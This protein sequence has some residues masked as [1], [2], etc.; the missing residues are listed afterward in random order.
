MSE[1]KP[2]AGDGNEGGALPNI[3]ELLEREDE[4]FVSLHELL[5]AMAQG[6]RGH[7]S[8]RRT[9]LAAATQEHRPG[10]P[11]FVVQIGSGSRH[12]R[13]WWRTRERTM[14]LSEAGR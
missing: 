5:T 2:A 11:A 3:A 1:N 13:D 7:V 14:D 12:H 10:R 4:D 6:Y 8:G 9:T